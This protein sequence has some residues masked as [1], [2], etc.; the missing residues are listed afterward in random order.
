MVFQL[1]TVCDQDGESQC[2]NMYFCEDGGWRSG[3]GYTLSL[4]GRGKKH[5]FELLLSKLNKKNQA[6]S[7][8]LG[9]PLRFHD[10]QTSL[11][12]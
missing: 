12:K 11:C 10:L 3:R 5:K 9:F 6:S 1:L 8:I 7:N 4:R 2:N